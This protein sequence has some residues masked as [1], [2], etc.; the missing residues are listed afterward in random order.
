MRFNDNRTQP[1]NVVRGYGTTW[2][3]VPMYE[4]EV[5]L[6][7][8]FYDD[9]DSL[10][11]PPVVRVI[12]VAER[13]IEE[14]SF[15]CQIQYDGPN[16]TYI[17]K[18]ELG[19]IGVG[20][21]R[22]GKFFREFV[23]SCPL[24]TH[25]L[26]PKYVS[27]TSENHDRRGNLTA[28]PIEIP[29]K[30]SEKKDFISC[31]SVTFYKVDPYRIVE[32]MELH[33]MWGLHKV[34]IYNNS[35]DTETA[36]IFQHYHRDGFVDFRQSPNF[37]SDPGDLSI[38]IQMSPVLND[39][40]YRNMYRARK[41]VVTDLDEMIVPR[42]KGN[43]KEMLEA[44][45]KAQPNYHPAK[46]Y[47][48]RNDYFF[49]ELPQTES[50]SKKLLTLRYQHRLNPS[51]H[52]YSVKSITDAQSCIC[53]HNHYCWK[54]TKLHDT[55]GHTTYVNV[56]LAMN[57]HYKKCHFGKEKCDSMMK[58]NVLDSTMVRFKDKL[59][60]RVSEKLKE[61]NLDPV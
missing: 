31:V 7:T 51:P 14:R 33:R 46:S 29:E 38:L 32:W 24:L 2:H 30:P 56:D 53:L 45:D 4:L 8:A 15:F 11:S 37:L 60:T 16:E 23:I 39:C 12:S 50:E 35:I 40:M 44:I 13:I 36:R 61:L 26:A 20:V 52:G 5:Y 48:F 49:F 1:I 22:H 9:R 3:R 34:T 47:M 18:G 58:E 25:P 27:L 43:Y 6:Y 28:L 19:A 17:V 59:V 55:S 57:Q 10:G 42:T 21:W 41:L 54:K